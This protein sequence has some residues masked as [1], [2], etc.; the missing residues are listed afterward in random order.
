M[1]LVDTNIWLE[2]LLNQ[3]RSDEVGKFLRVTSSR[4]LYLTDFA[5]HSICVVLARL[6][7]TNVLLDFVEDVFVQGSVNLVSIAPSDIPLLVDAMNRNNFDFD[8][9]YQY[10]AAQQNQLR[11][12]SFD[13]DFD[14]VPNLRKTPATIL[15][16]L[17]EIEQADTSE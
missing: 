3:A 14:R 6:A 7:R 13:S 15:D 8:D 11:I 10:V 1:Y 9:A 5:F 17:S 16:E 2:R 12:I 4:E